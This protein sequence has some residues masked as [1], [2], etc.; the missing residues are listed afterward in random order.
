MKIPL[1]ILLL[2][3]FIVILVYSFFYFA[4]ILLSPSFRQDFSD[5]VCIKENCFYVESV[6]KEAER[7]RGLMNR[8]KLDKDSGML[9]LFEKNDVYPFWMKNTLIPLD[10]VWI[11]E[12]RKIVYI[13]KDNKP[14]VES[15][16]PQ[17]NP[18]I[19]SRYVL[20]INAGISSD[21]GLEIGDEVKL[22]VK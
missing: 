16:C 4:D 3:I 10:I 17:I 14:C 15:D 8:E 1:K 20:E 18:G 2:I 12:D 6:K 22:N 19:V 21:I 13:S 11:N 7:E 9:F 5:S